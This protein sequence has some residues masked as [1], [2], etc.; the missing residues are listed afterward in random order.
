MDVY[1]SFSNVINFK[2]SNISIQGIYKRYAILFDKIIFNRYGCPIGNNNLFA[3]LTEYTS[4]FA[5][6]EK[7]LKK[8]LNL[9]K[10]KKFQDLFIDLWDLFENP[11]SL[12]NEARNY[13][14]EHQSETIS[15]FSWGRTLIDKE[16]GI[17]NHNSEYKAASIVWGDISSDLG[18]NFLL[19]NNHKNLH[20]NFAPVVASAV[21]SAQQTSNIQNLF[22]TDLI[23][24]NFE[25]LTWEQVLELREDKYIKAF[26]KKYFS[27]EKNDKNIDLELNSDLDEALW[28]LASQIRPNITKSIMEAVL[29]NLPFPSIA[30]PFGIYYGARDTL[31]NIENKNNHSWVYFI[32]SAK[33]TNIIK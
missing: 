8:K 4:T 16:M 14:S 27:I 10:N 20:I 26:R 15:K 30:N 23:I 18:F 33:K 2:R 31:R 1:S 29:S 25:E 24:P 12:N 19:K 17:H 7:D 5:S 9:S 28:D 13:V 22:A 6:D 11:E 3:S 21:N 32:Q